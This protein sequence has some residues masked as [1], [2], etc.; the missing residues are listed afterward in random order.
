MKLL[1]AW[2]HKDGTS[3]SWTNGDTEEHV[4]MS[5]IAFFDSVKRFAKKNE[6]TF[7]EAFD[8]IISIAKRT[9]A[10]DEE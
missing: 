3:R 10:I 5:S 8:K 6:I 2:L 9:N 1:I 7:D 4:C